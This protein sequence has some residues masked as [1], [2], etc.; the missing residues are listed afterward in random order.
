MTLKMDVTEYPG[1][2]VT[3][4]VLDDSDKTFTV[5]A[6]EIWI[7]QF[8]S[9]NYVSTATV[10]NRQVRVDI[11]D[12]TRVLWFKEFGAVQAASLTRNYYAAVDLPDDVAFDSGGR[13]QMK[14]VEHTLPAGY[15][16][17]VYDVAAIAAAAD[18]M[19]VYLQGS[20]FR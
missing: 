11:G 12:G 10:G 8:L 6:G 7:P 20:T 19:K 4:E 3:D 15:T 1:A 9:V 13:I 2:L 14:V 17:R 16:I 5:P 18:D